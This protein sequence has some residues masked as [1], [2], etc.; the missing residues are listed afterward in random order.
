VCDVPLREGIGVAAGVGGS[1]KP[2][3]RVDWR[4]SGGSWIGGGFLGRGRRKVLHSM[5]EQERFS[6]ERGM[7][8]ILTVGGVDMFSVYWR[9]KFIALRDSMVFGWLSD[10][11]VWS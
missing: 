9:S 5:Q 7:A 2:R 4:R 3:P 8:S 1:E 6:L 11:G 10:H